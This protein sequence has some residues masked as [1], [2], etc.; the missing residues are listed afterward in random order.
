MAEFGKITESTVAAAESI[1][2]QR[3]MAYAEMRPQDF[4]EDGPFVS[5]DHD[6]QGM[7]VKMRLFV[8][9]YLGESKGDAY[10]AYVRAGYPDNN[11]QEVKRQAKRLLAM[12]A[13]QGAIARRFSKQLLGVEWAK[14]TLAAMANSDMSNFVD[15][16]GNFD[17]EKAVALGALGQIKE[18]KVSYDPDT[19]NV[20]R[21]EI[22]L[23]D[24]LQSV[25]MLLK[26][27]GVLRDADKDTNS[28]NI[29]VNIHETM[30]QLRDNPVVF[31][32][33]KELAESM[34]P[35]KRLGSNN[36]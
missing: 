12:P 9:A 25:V 26:V 23:Y 5:G 11:S 24:K 27:L 7:T 36:E 8:L 14:N 20:T 10:D 3:A 31:A 16:D 33:A 15:A 29:A 17:M 21:R 22:K 13:V 35:V 4:I 30:Q 1:P 2:V 28:I 34:S 6:G 32:K 18:M 19:G